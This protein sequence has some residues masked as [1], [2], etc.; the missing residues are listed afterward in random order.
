MVL[1]KPELDKLTK[2][3]F[4]VFISFNFYLSSMETDNKIPNKK[5]QNLDNIF[6]Y[7]VAQQTGG[8]CGYHALYNGLT[9]LKALEDPSKY[10]LLTSNEDRGNYF[11]SIDSTWTKEIIK[12][13]IRT[14][15]KYY[16]A[17]HLFKSFK[18]IEI[19]SKPEE[20]AYK[21]N[22]S[23]NWV[24]LKQFY[25]DLKNIE[26]YRKK[27]INLIV[28]VSSDI[29]NRLIIFEKDQATC[30]VDKQDFINIFKL[31]YKSQNFDKIYEVIDFSSINFEIISD[32][33][34]KNLNKPN[35]VYVIN[36]QDIS[37]QDRVKF[38]VNDRQEVSNEAN[39]GEWLTSEEI[40]FLIETDK[41]L[42]HT[43]I[44]CIDTLKENEIKELFL[45]NAS[46]KQLVIDFK[47]KDYS[48]TA[49]FL[50][51]FP[52]HWITCVLTKDKDSLPNFILMDS[53][54][55]K[56]RTCSKK[57]FNLIKQIYNPEVIYSKVNQTKSNFSGYNAAY[58]VLTN[59]ELL[60]NGSGA[61]LFSKDNDIKFEEFTSSSKKLIIQNRMR[62]LVEYYIAD[63]LLKSLKS[64]DIVSEPSFNCYKLNLSDKYIKLKHLNLSLF[65]LEELRK[66]FC[67]L[68]YKVACDLVED[69]VYFEDDKATVIVK[70]QD[71]IDAFEYRY[72]SFKERSEIIAKAKEHFIEFSDLKFE[73]IFDNRINDL[74]VKD[75]SKIYTINWS[76]FASDNFLTRFN[77][78]SKDT[79][80]DEPGSW[81]STDEI[82]SLFR[83]A[84]CKNFEFLKDLQIF[85][86]DKFNDE[87]LHEIFEKSDNLRRSFS[88]FIN[89]NTRGSLLF[90]L[91]IAKH[92]VPLIMT[93]KIGELPRF[94]LADS[95]N[96]QGDYVC[97]DVS[98]LINFLSGKLKDLRNSSDEEL[99]KFL[100]KSRPN[101]YL[102]NFDNIFQYK[103]IS[104]D[105]YSG[106][107]SLY[108]AIVVL[109]SLDC[110]S[111]FQL[112][113][114]YE[115][116]NKFFGKADSKWTK[117]I[118]EARVKD[119][120]K[121]F[122][123]DCLFK[124][125]RKTEIISEFQDKCYKLNLSNEW[126]KLSSMASNL[127][128]NDKDEFGFS[129]CSRLS[130]ERTRKKVCQMIYEVAEIL[131]NNFVKYNN[132]F[133]YHI[134][135]DD[136][137][138]IFENCFGQKGET[139]K[140]NICDIINLSDLDFEV[141][142]DYMI[143]NLN[144]N[145]KVYKIN[146]QNRFNENFADLI[147]IENVTQ[148]D[149]C[150]PGLWIS[151]EE[152][153]N[154]ISLE[155]ISKIDIPRDIFIRCVDI[156]KKNVIQE[157]LKK[158]IDFREFI[159][160]FNNIDY[161]G[162]AILLFSHKNYWITC[163][164]NKNKKELA[165]VFLVNCY[166]NSNSAYLDEIITFIKLISEVSLEKPN[167]SKKDKNNTK[168]FNE[169]LNSNTIEQDSDTFDKDNK[170]E[171]LA[172][173]FKRIPSIMFRDLI[174]DLPIEIKNLVQSIKS[175]ELSDKDIK[176]IL[177][178]GAPGTGKTSLAEAIAKET[179]SDFYY[180]N[181][182]SLI[183]SYQGSG[184]ESIN[185]VFNYTENSSKNSVIFIDEVDAITNNDINDKNGESLR[186]TRNLQCNLSQ[187]KSI[188]ILATNYPDKLPQ[189]LKDRFITVEI[190]LPMVVDIVDFLRKGLRV[191]GYYSSTDT[192]QAIANMFN[193]LNYRDLSKILVNSTSMI[194][195]RSIEDRILTEKDYIVAIYN[196]RPKMIIASEEHAKALLKYYL[197]IYGL[198]LQDVTFNN[199]WGKLFKHMFKCTAE[200]VKNTV[201]NIK[202]RALNLRTLTINDIYTGM[203]WEQNGTLADQNLRFTILKHLIN[204]KTTSDITDYVYNDIAAEAVDNFTAKDLQEVV[205]NA[206][207]SVRWRG[208]KFIK[209]HD[210]YIGLYSVLQKKAKAVQIIV[211]DH[212][213]STLANEPKSGLSGEA[214]LGA[215]FSIPI[216]APIPIS[217]PINLRGGYNSSA[218][219]NYQWFKNTNVYHE[220]RDLAENE[221]FLRNDIEG[222]SQNKKTR[223]DYRTEKLPGYY[224]RLAVIKYFLHNV[225]H[226][227]SKEDIRKFA[228]ITLDLTCYTLKEIIN[229]GDRMRYEERWHNKPQGIF[230]SKYPPY[231]FGNK[232][233]LLVDLVKA[234]DNLG[235]DLY[236]GDE[237]K[238]KETISQTRAKYKAKME[239]F[240]DRYKDKELQKSMFGALSYNFEALLLLSNVQ[241]LVK[242]FSKMES[243]DLDKEM[244]K[245][246]I[247]DIT[248]N[249]IKEIFNLSKILSKDDITMR[250]KDQLIAKY[251]AA[252]TMFGVIDTINRAKKF[253]RE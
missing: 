107:Y 226:D 48:G 55:N 56:N 6:Q 10:K 50:L 110:K 140:D 97:D 223:L 149:I 142:S 195:S 154:I 218:S 60:E 88:S 62:K 111:N 91:D 136:I 169:F 71:I 104:Q 86:I 83:L 232:K 79:V 61:N 239:Q 26:E 234:A 73:V 87:S 227:L 246:G 98:K 220:S 114:D 152:L 74:S 63:H 134:R 3:L 120:A 146:W 193:D 66:E 106:Y 199:F 99:R 125:L 90:M 80:F 67:D 148:F 31:F 180:L 192:L 174:G 126:I 29:A 129:L 138:R 225:N 76:C 94:I 12:K 49:I 101:N 7:E 187:N 157:L 41:K 224:L 155:K 113:S 59:L 168:D 105:Y 30:R 121:A 100:E 189:P 28:D 147:D 42:K 207:I 64:V 228:E 158:D 1:C 163:V 172:Q 171:T 37:N 85:W 237:K 45:L 156:S 216:P 127:E 18:N 182:G 132:K 179:N 116:R 69:L 9:L 201:T 77:G 211:G 208:L 209:S 119:L 130:I 186:A 25:S 166:E 139:I 16:I 235:I 96:N 197:E 102:K 203:Y 212:T 68:I 249:H 23:N 204:D 5:F 32:N 151:K 20:N 185:A 145:S 117:Y 39:A 188:C 103:N 245:L 38:Y 177:L 82:D 242:D 184:S 135:S 27:F 221:K 200:N 53:Y 244:S 124:S 229:L 122:I 231:E 161:S 8:T 137:F 109:N 47:S 72:R 17:D 128:E 93:K 253:S 15:A 118:T 173:S 24:K 176:N 217:L 2:I 40:E 43:N 183:T 160:N 133:V 170:Q 46:L 35:E 196:Q 222:G 54:Y 191:K 236:R 153:E 112:F 13:R 194:K 241:S 181:A 214:S 250:D 58:N 57:I 143:V 131:S 205:D 84:K 34:I 219:Q 210:L 164:I 175:E 248:F 238:L 95:R 252:Y 247:G 36:W 14:L 251:I 243:Y 108:N 123:S 19:I 233:L 75:E 70:K 51:Y 22:L 11:G 198:Q 150:D 213:I 33:K 159:D 115:F 89:A 190:K 240:K 206:M 78:I 162:M 52:K 202:S 92:W 81:L 141:I 167:V 144:N 230:E 65:H 4:G 178:V 165:K 21:L 44:F 215:S